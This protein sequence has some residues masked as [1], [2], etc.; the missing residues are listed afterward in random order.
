M[1]A[2]LA[3]GAAFSAAAGGNAFEV[4]LA[5]AALGR[6]RHPRK[7]DAFD[8]A[9]PAAA[10]AAAVPKSSLQDRLPRAYPA[11]AAAGDGYWVRDAPPPLQPQQQQQQQQQ[12]HPSQLPPPPQQQQ[13]Q[14]PAPAAAPAAAAWAWQQD[15][16]GL[17]GM[18]PQQV[19]PLPHIYLRGFVAYFPMVSPYLSYISLRSL[20]QGM[21]PQQVPPLPPVS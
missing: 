9:V 3:A 13:Q 4:R 20:Q 21:D 19:P 11:G 5:P 8:T 7:S 10:A 17:Q 18:D 6:L 1:D 16:T 12:Q 15:P 14:Q 2:L